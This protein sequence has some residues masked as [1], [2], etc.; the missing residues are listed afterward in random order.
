MQAFFLFL[1][2]FFGI[3]GAAVFLRIAYNAAVS[4]FTKRRKER[5]RGGK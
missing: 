4:Y 3:F 5:G 2:I 1:I